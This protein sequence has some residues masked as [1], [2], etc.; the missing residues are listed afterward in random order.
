MNG[1]VLYHNYLVKDNLYFKD[2]NNVSNSYSDFEIENIPKS[3]NVT[4]DNDWKYYMN[5]KNELPSQGWKIHISANINEVYEVLKAASKVLIEY[6]I[7]FKHLINFSLYTK[8][9][10]KNARSSEIW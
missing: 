8:T 10:S 5:I 9:N 4:Y 1:N 2:T 6:K 7:S 3:Y